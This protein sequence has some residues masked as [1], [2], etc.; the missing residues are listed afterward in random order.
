MNK[1]IIFALLALLAG[2]TI[3]NAQ[4]NNATLSASNITIGTNRLGGTQITISSTSGVAAV[5]INLSYDPGV[6]ELVNASRGNFDYWFGLHNPQNGST[7]YA[8]I[9]TFALPGEF[10]GN[11]TVATVAFRAVGNASDSSP[12]I[13]SPIVAANV[14]GRNLL[15][16]G[17]NATISITAADPNDTN[18]DGKTNILDAAL[19]VKNF[20]PASGLLYPAY[21]VTQNGKTDEEDIYAVGQN[22]THKIF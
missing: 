17:Y 1:K 4:E 8:M 13:I 22:F 18:R 15:T 11:S 7:G 20:N 14:S 9:N 3:A 12:L 10:T 16:T 2:I 6:I 5:G 21:D 19:I